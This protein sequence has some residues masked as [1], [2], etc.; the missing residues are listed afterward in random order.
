MLENEQP[1]CLL[2][3]ARNSCHLQWV[4]R[5]QFHEAICGK[6][7][8]LFSRLAN[9]A[10]QA[11]HSTYYARYPNLNLRYSGDPTTLPSRP[12]GLKTAVGKELGT[13]V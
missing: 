12:V 4:V 8:R 10:A 5:C 2:V 7:R 13:L 1:S 3:P 9:K 11:Y 6:K